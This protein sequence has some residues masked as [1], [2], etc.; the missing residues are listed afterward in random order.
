MRTAFVNILIGHT[1]T[2]WGHMLKLVIT[3]LTY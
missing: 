3:I 2:F 1:T